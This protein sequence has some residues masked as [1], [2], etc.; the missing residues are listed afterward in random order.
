MALVRFETGD[1]ALARRAGWLICL[2]PAAFTFVMGYAEGT[3]LLLSAG[4]F[5][6]LRTRHWWWA[7]AAGAGRRA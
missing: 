4:T 1:E 6:A 3:L 5:F 2:A 7:A